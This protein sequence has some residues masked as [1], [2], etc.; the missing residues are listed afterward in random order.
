MKIIKQKVMACLPYALE[1]HS[2]EQNKLIYTE[3]NIK[4]AIG[5]DTDNFLLL[6]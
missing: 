1:F 4:L 2:K 5:K 6:T 3:E